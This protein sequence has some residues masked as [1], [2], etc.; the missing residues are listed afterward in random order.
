MTLN[1]RDNGPRSAGAPSLPC[2]SIVSTSLTVIA[3][4]IREELNSRMTRRRADTGNNSPMA[5]HLS[6]LHRTW[7]G[8]LH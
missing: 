1:L 6:C 5:L 4:W 7:L 8:D 2:R 3:F